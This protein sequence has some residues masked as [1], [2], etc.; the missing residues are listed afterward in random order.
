MSGPTVLLIW[1]LG[2]GLGHISRLLPIAKGLEA[3]GVRCVFAVRNVE[4][5]HRVLGPAGFP[6]LQ[7]PMTVPVTDYTGGSAIGSFG[8]IM[9]TI[10][11][12]RA[13]RL[14]AMVA[15]WDATYD[16][17]RPDLIVADYAPTAMLAAQGRIP[18]V[19]I[20]DWFTLPPSGMETFAPLRQGGARIP[21]AEMLAAIRQVQAARGA[22]EVDRMPAI[23]E[24]ARPF[25]ITLPELDRY[26]DDR[27]Y[28]ASGPLSPLPAP[29]HGV[30][31]TVDYFAYL[32]LGYPHTE[33]V[34]EAFVGSGFTGSIYLRDGSNARRA[35]W[36]DK[37]LVVHDTPQDMVEMARQAAVIVHHGGIGTTETVLALGRPQLFVPRHLEQTVNGGMV[38]ERG[39]AVSLYS[40][41]RFRPEHVVQ[42]L[43]HAR[44]N[45]EI[46]DRCRRL[47]D[48]LAAR[49]PFG[50]VGEIVGCCLGL[51]DRR[52]PHSASA[53]P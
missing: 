31:P 28:P 12:R 49:G 3:G 7:V 6:M 21:E 26:R 36:R 32:S 25:V 8:D 35:A 2:D 46:A 27:A 13:D 5:C 43:G 53:A 22:V 29:V 14:A 1:E 48:D 47:A 34:L 52:S 30:T 40:G 20:G 11:Y 50:A 24:C 9:E 18:V 39:L 16:I 19:A 15:A 41:G 17:V 45:V 51:L 44:S 37:G 33:K 10:G 23:L 38:G 42:A 4:S